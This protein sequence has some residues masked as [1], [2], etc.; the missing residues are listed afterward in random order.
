MVSLWKHDR[1]RAVKRDGRQLI[2][3]IER[4]VGVGAL[5]VVV[6]V[7][8]LSLDEFVENTTLMTMLRL[9]GT[10]HEMIGLLHIHT[11]W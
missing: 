1:L 10:H 7:V 6:R 8:V 3:L 4:L 11:L 9:S 5:M 2:L